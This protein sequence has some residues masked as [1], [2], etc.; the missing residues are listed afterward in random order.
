VPRAIAGDAQWQYVQRATADLNGD[1]RNEIAVLIADVVLDARGEPL[2]DDG[3]RWQV[4]IEEPDS[5]RTYVYARFLPH[6]K[7]EAS[8]TVPDEEKMPTIVLR[9]LTPHLLGVYE[10][11]YAG[12][13]RATAVRHLHRELDPAKGFVTGR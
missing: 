11:R 13:Q 7:L 12:P 2:W 3:H 1:G 5:T 9:E 10:V 8:V 4:Y 6:G